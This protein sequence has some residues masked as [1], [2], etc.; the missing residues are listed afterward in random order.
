[1]TNTRVLVIGEALIDV[2]DR[3]DGS[4]PVRH[5]GGSPLNV[6]FGLARLGIPTTFATEFGD[7]ADGAA[8][9]AHLAGAGVEVARTAAGAHRTATA[10][11]RIQPDGSAEYVFDIDWT[12]P[13]PP[14][15]DRADVVHIGSIGSLRAPGAVGVLALVEGL[16]SDVLVTFD[17]NVR[18]ALLPSV[19]ETRALV[20]RYAARAQVVKLSDEDAA[21]LY[22]EDPSSAPARLLAQGARL[23][24][25][26]HG[27]EGSVVHTAGGERRVPARRTAAV[28]TIGAGDAYM[29][30]LIA[31]LLPHAD[32]L[33]GGEGLDADALDAVGRVAATT[34]SLTVA[35]AGAMPPT[36]EELAAALAG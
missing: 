18:P 33:T 3:G 31:A 8:I 34:S 23:V 13:Q 35:R 28:D 11:A 5:V 25:V 27:A 26:T 17:P 10:L 20:E 6:A 36:A 24:A 7:D 12:F 15:T 9:A 22:P 14:P 19:V 21:W 32:A 29:S 1:M 4:A 2:V 30:G 16:P